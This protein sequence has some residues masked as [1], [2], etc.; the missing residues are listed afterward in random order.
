MHQPMKHLSRGFTL[1]EVIVVMAIVALLAAASMPMINDYSINSRLREGG[2]LLLADA[3]YAQSEALK[4]NA[5]VT[6]NV[7]TLAVNVVDVTSGETLRARDLP[8]GVFATSHS[9]TFGGSGRPATFGD[10]A[11]IDLSLSGTS[12]SE[13]Y[14]CPRLIIDGGGGVRLC[15]NQLDCT[16]L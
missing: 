13:L 9:I 3:L 7:T 6:F 5:R 8:N 2:S 4:R 14:R 1:I 12:C 11:D 16:A 10:S 15:G